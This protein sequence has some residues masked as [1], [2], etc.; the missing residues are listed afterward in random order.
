MEARDV[1]AARARARALAQGVSVEPIGPGQWAAE[2]ST[3]AG[4]AYLLTLD[5]HGRPRCT[6]D[7][8]RWRLACKHAARL[9]MILAAR[10]D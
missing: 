6:C 3:R 9:E 10:R 5:E 1:V 7:G 8:Y 4:T 2:S